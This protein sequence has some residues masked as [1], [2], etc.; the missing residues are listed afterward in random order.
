MVISN[1]SKH[2]SRLE[3]DLPLLKY[4]AK[5]FPSISFENTLIICV[6]HLLPTTYTLFT[7]LFKMGLSPKNLAVLGK[8]YSTD[9][10]VFE[11]LQAEG[12]NVCPSS[13]FFD[14]HIS[15]DQMYDQNVDRFLQKILNHYDLL[16]YEQVI[17][18]DDGGHLLEGVHRFGIRHPRLI[19][20]EQTSAGY[21]RTKEIGLN[22]PIINLARAWSK[23]KYETPMIMNS[24]LSK[25]KSYMDQ[26]ATRNSRVLVLG[27]GNLGELVCNA[28]RDRFKLL[29]FDRDQTK[30]SIT[31]QQL[32]ASISNAN[33]IIGCTGTV[34]LSEKM[35]PYIKP[36]TVLV[37]ISSSD[38]EFNAVSLR[39]CVPQELN[40]HRD[41]LIN[42]IHLLNCG[43]PIN[44]SSDYSAV[45]PDEYQFT[46]SLIL[47]CLAQ[48]RSAQHRTP[49]YHD[50]NS[51][52]QEKIVEE[53]FKAHKRK[54]THSAC[55]GTFH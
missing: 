21:N 52:I 51:E 44:F 27:K 8:C 53:N 15:Y 42:G 6:Q 48:A 23:L 34:S 47:A 22:F 20:I 41:L 26:S 36:S 35:H 14:S 46:R 11:Q 28:L 49:G 39:K 4:T 29:V 19:G 9:P 25:L 43:F 2:P 12:V 30:S 13:S 17:I 45:D 55:Y 50:L 1:N 32:P 7:L 40:C 3:R 10:L 33:I 31:E 38:R 24:C 16:V 54:E 18:L 37:S 5:Q